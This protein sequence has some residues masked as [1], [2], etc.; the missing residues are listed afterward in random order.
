MFTLIACPLMVNFLAILVARVF[1]AWSH[2]C[3]FHFF[4]DI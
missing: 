3:F 1:T 2:C 4:P